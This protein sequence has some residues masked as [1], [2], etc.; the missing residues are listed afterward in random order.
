MNSW[1]KKCHTMQRLNSSCFWTES[2]QLNS[3]QQHE[4][5]YIRLPLPLEWYTQ[6]IKSPHVCPAGESLDFQVRLRVF[7][8]WSN[9]TL[10]L[11]MI[12]LP[13][14]SC[15]CGGWRWGCGCGG[16]CGWL[17]RETG[18][19]TWIPLRTPVSLALSTWRPLAAGRAALTEGPFPCQ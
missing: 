9:Q 1:N 3:C 2:S 15:C 7:V 13:D 6:Y 16:G 5:H 19:S 4:G 17:S 10:L 12:L 18:R 8:L 11:L 14:C